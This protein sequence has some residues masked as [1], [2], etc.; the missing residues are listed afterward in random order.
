MSLVAFKQGPTTHLSALLHGDSRPDS[1]GE[2]S[3]SVIALTRKLLGAQ[4]YFRC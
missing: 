2:L 3:A 4:F 1:E